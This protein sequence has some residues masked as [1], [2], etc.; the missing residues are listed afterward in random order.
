M[1]AGSG[2]FSPTTFRKQHL[3]AFNIKTISDKTWLK[4]IQ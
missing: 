2:D 3:K 4:G 1:E